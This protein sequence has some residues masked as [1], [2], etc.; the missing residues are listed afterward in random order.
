MFKK[1]IHEARENE[2]NVGEMRRGRRSNRKYP[3]KAEI[4]IFCQS[5]EEVLARIY[6]R[7]EVKKAKRRRKKPVSVHDETKVLEEV[8]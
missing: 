3:T 6:E 5:T 1:H 2:R 8:A 4:D 7:C